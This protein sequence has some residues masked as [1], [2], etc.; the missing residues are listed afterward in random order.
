MTCFM[1][2]NLSTAILTKGDSL[3]IQAKQNH[4][5]L[6]SLA[7]ASGLKEIYETMELVLHYCISSIPSINGIFVEISK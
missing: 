6:A 2:L 1:A 7:H 5:L 3:L 4:L